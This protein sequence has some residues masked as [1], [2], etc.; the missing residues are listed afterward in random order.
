MLR[1]GDFAK[2]AR[3]SVKALR[4]YDEAGLLAPAFVDRAT[5]YRYYEAGQLET[6]GRILLL[7]DLGFELKQIVGLLSAS[8]ALDAALEARSQA[9]AAQIAEDQW[10]LKRLEAFR[11]ALAANPEPPAVRV[12]AIEPQHAL[13]SRERVRNGDGRVTEL[14]ETLEAEAA[15]IGARA[16][17]SPFLLLHDLEDEAQPE[18]EVC[19]PVKQDVRLP[20]VRLVEGASRAGTVVFQG[21]YEQTPALF[22]RLAD[23]VGASG[24]AIAGPLREVYHR[25]GADQRGYRLPERVL[26]T[27]AHDYVTELQVPIATRKE[28]IP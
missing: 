2:L 25:F 11:Q 21:G 3:V 8:Q 6:L 20:T 4:L 13:T 19:V 27:G 26:A 15:R 16:D 23:W 1:I 17:V 14:F 22:A 28:S 10:R 9:L 5:G 7:K 12:R 24:S 18:V